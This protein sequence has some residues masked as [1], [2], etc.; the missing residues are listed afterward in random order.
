MTAALATGLHAPAPRPLVVDA[1]MFW[2]TRGGGV[3]RYLRD[4]HRWAPRAG[5]RSAWVVP[6]AA[7]AGG[8]AVGGLPLPASGGYRMPWPSARLPALLTRLR[9]DVIEAG[10]PFALGGAALA[11]ARALGVPAV[12]FLHADL[13]EQARRALGRGAAR[14]VRAWL[15]RRLAS[16]DA[17]FAASTAAV[18]MARELGL[19]NVVRQ[20][21]GVDLERF[22]PTRDAARWRAA[23]GLPADARVLLFVGRFAAEKDLPLLARVAERL[24][25]PYL[26]VAVGAGPTPPAGPRVRVVPYCN[27]AR[28]LA[29]AYSAADAFVHG[30]TRETFGLAALEALACG[31]PAV[32]PAR[33]GFLDLIDGRAVLGVEPHVEAFAEALRALAEQD[34]AALAE[35]ARAAAAA[36]D[37]HRAFALLFSRYDALRMA[38]ARRD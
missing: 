20:P 30:G 22:R 26:L 27:D 33:A 3:G 31:T 24:G 6:H 1:T 23:H 4:K 19:D 15:R 35:R 28:D 38:R 25:P 7:G 2:S 36:H 17:A 21:L 34:R 5:W 8:I 12:S 29:A 32:L 13:V 11:A 37:Q 9:P 10:D 14:A 18:D 16:F